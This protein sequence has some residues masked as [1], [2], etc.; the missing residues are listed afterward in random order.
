[1][2]HDLEAAADEV[3]PQL[4]A[5]SLI[6]AFD[7]FDR[8][9]LGAVPPEDVATRIDPVFAFLRGGLAGLR[10]RVNNKRQRHSSH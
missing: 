2:A 10:T 1:M 5:A 3:R 7:A 6:A 4:V 9:A 8:P